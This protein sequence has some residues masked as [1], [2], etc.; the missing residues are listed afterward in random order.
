METFEK[1]K[2]IFCGALDLYFGG[3]G[4]IKHFRNEILHL[5]SFDAWDINVLPIKVLD[6]N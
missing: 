2:P 3:S 1:K 4:K 6:K 5:Y